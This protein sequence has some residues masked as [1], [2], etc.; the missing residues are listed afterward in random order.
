M[1][2]AY[3]PVTMRDKENRRDLVF[4]LHNRLHHFQ[5]FNGI[6]ITT[7]FT[8]VSCGKDYLEDIIEPD[9]ASPPFIV[10][11]SHILTIG[12][13]KNLGKPR[14]SLSP[15]SLT[16]EIPMSPFRL[17]AEK[18]SP[19]TP[20][21]CKRH[22]EKP[23]LPSLSKD[24]FSLDDSVEQAGSRNR[25]TSMFEILLSPK[26][27]S[28]SPIANSEEEKAPRRR[29]R[30][31]SIHDIILQQQPSEQPEQPGQSDQPDQ[32]SQNK[33]SKQMEFTP[34]TEPPAVMESWID[35]E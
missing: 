27:G 20:V 26:E 11:S 32:T 34:F 3:N 29:N 14:D 30:T 5:L 18:E 22:Q 23:P 9:L 13:Q 7:L 16:T 31:F 10:P 21:F 35:D 25:S 17:D 6:H 33:E 12:K 2:L 24:L 15:L 19:S 1:N 28:N 8:R 4:F